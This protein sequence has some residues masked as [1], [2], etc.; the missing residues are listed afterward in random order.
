[1]VSDRS[2]HVVTYLRTQAADL[3]DTDMHYLAYLS[4]SF[5]CTEGLF[6]DLP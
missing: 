3:V 2:P 4:C 6:A 1:M 5:I